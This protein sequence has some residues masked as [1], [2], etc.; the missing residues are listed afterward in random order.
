MKREHSIAAVVYNDGKF[1]LLKYGL[2][3]WGFV[4]GHQEEGETNKQT[5]LRELKEETGIENA[6]ILDDFK[7]KYD[8]FFRFRGNL[9]HKT[10]DCYLIEAKDQSVQLSFEHVD[11]A[12]LPI[13]RAIKKA[14]YENAKRILKKKKKFLRNSK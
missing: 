5:I 12:W 9:I 4:K 3:H 10:V 7:E 8:Y 14:T 6:E 1:L 2:G 13:D 11:Y